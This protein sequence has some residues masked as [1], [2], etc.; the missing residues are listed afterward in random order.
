[1]KWGLYSAH[2]Y[3]P[4]NATCQ[5]SCQ[6]LL[7]THQVVPAAL[8]FSL[9]LTSSSFHMQAQVLQEAAH[10][11]AVSKVHVLEALHVLPPHLCSKPSSLA[12]LGLTLSP[13]VLGALA[14][15]W[16]PRWIAFSCLICVADSMVYD[17]LW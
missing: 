5:S 2:V 3:S 16:S 10:R 7:G 17:G 14:S 4:M 1:M 11:E 15:G 8:P 9:L 6:L 13:P 12:V